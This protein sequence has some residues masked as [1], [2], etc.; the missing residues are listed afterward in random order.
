MLVSEKPAGVSENE[1]ELCIF[2]N[3][4]RAYYTFQITLTCFRSTETCKRN[5]YKLC[6]GILKTKPVRNGDHRRRNQHTCVYMPDLPYLKGEDDIFSS[7][8][9]PP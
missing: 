2:V 5:L 9:T 6:Q 1:S 4:C 3:A 7:L 8:L